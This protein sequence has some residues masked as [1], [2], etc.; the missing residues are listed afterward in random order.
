MS[1]DE[2]S[3]PPDPRR[4]DPLLEKW[5]SG[6]QWLRCHNVGF[7]ATE[8]N[9]GSGRG[10]FH[11][12]ASPTGAPVPS[13]YGA[14]TMD[15]ALAETVFRS[16]TVLGPR[17]LVR[18]S[19]LLPMVVSTLA[20]RRDLVLAQLHGFGLDRLGISRAGLIDAGPP[21]Y[22]ASALWAQAIHRCN[23]RIDGLVWVSR[24]HDTSFALVLFGDRVHRTELSVV[25]PPVP[26]HDGPGLARVRQAAD[27]AAIILLE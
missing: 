15:G 26:L 8:F 2:T 19:A 27:Q 14:T 16:I 24:L 20:A 13:L 4:L 25:E 3:A 18:S 21:H 17:R 12:F 5:K 9:P 11:P 6:T 1:T 23:L 10:R 7:G 22:P